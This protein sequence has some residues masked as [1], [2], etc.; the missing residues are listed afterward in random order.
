MAKKHAYTAEQT[1]FILRMNPRF[2]MEEDGSDLKYEF[3]GRKYAH[4]LI[5]DLPGKSSLVD[6]VYDDLVTDWE[7]FIPDEDH[8]VLSIP[9]MEFFTQRE[10]MGGNVP[11]DRLLLAEVIRVWHEDR[12]FYLKSLMD[13]TLNPMV[14][15]LTFTDPNG[16]KADI[17][18][19]AAELGI[20]AVGAEGTYDQST[21]TAHTEVYWTV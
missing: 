6:V 14:D 19:T 2:D 10:A 16:E 1:K 8:I 4:R 20:T 7:H 21:Q 9:S 12:L 5:E 3:E 18:L 17:A 13:P 11:E 15:K